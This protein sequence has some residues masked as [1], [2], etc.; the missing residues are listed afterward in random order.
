MSIIELEKS[1]I[2]TTGSGTLDI[3]SNRFITT[4]LNPS[5]S[6]A[7]NITTPMVVGYWWGI[8]NKSTSDPVDIYLNAVFQITLNNSN[9]LLGS[10]IRVAAASTTVL[11][12]V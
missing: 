12:I 3:T 4:I 10:T 8:C 11:Y 1:L 6:L 2:N 9:A 5:G 7:V